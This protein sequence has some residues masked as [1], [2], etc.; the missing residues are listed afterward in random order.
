MYAK[1]RNGK[2]AL[3]MAHRKA[4]DHAEQIAALQE[5]LEALQAQI[6]ALAE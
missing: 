3:A 6:A 4:T 2:L 1:V 5:Q